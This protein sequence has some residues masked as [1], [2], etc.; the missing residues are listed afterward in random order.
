MPYDEL[1]GE[2]PP[3]L[4]KQRRTGDVTGGGDAVQIL[5][6]TIYHE[7]VKYDYHIIHGGV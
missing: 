1:G 6:L 2:S 5:L 4:C 7:D 3:S